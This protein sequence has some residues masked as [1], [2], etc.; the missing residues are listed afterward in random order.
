MNYWTSCCEKINGGTITGLLLPIYL[1]LVWGHSAEAQV[2]SDGTLSTTIGSVG[3]DFT[4]TGGASSGNNLYHSFSQFSVPAGGSASFSNASNIEN[5]FARVTGG[6]TSS[7]DGLLQTNGSANLFLLN[8]VGILFGPNASLDVGGSFVASTANSVIFADGVQFSTTDTTS[9]VLLTVAT[10]VGLQLGAN[11]GSIQV[12]GSLAISR[13]NTLGLAGSQ[14]DMSRASLRAPDGQIE[15]WAVQNTQ[16]ATTRQPWQLTTTPADWGTVALQQASL[17]DASGTNGGAINV[18]G[19][20]LTLQGGSNIRSNTVTGQGRGITVQTTEF[21]DLLG[22]SLPGQFFPGIGTSVGSFFGPP[23][24]GRAGDVT[25]ETGRLSLSNG[26]SLQSSSSSNNS[27]SG[28]LTVRASDVEVVGFNPFFKSPTSITTTL[29]SG[30]NN[31]SGTVTIEAD[32]LSVIDGGLISTSLV[33]LNPAASLMGRSGNISIRATESFEISGSTPNDVLSGVSTGIQPFAEGQAGDITVD[34]GRLQISNGGSIRSSLAGTGQAGN[35]SIQA[36]EVSVSEPEIDRTSNLPGGITVAVG[37]DA[38][39]PGGTINL[40]ADRLR[41]FDGGQITSSSSGQGAAGNINLQVRDI[42]IQGISQAPV[43]GQYRSSAIAASSASTFDA[44]SVNLTADSI[45]VSDRGQVTVSN[46]GTGNAGNLSA[47]ARNILLDN[48]ASLRAEVNGGDQGNINLQIDEVLLLR[49]GSN[50]TTNAQ[51]A[52][53]GGNININAGFIVAVPD[54]NSDIVANA[55]LGSGGNINITT[56]G[57][58]GLEFRD[59]LTLQSDITASSEFGVNGTVNIDNPDIDPNSGII[60]LPSQLVDAS[61]QIASGCADVGENTFVATG[62]GGV[63][64]APGDEMA[65]PVWNDIRDFS[66]FVSQGEA[67]AEPVLTSQN[68]D[69]ITEIT[70]WLVNAEGQVELISTT[71]GEGGAMNE[72]IAYATCSSLG[73]PSNS[74][75]ASQ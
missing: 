29:F 32:R 10:P 19:R 51:G 41:V 53:T 54:E 42:D 44:G 57:I 30:T 52:S 20:G 64:P 59:Q 39:G 31:E 58:F 61:D 15:L 60:E 1:S 75:S 50:I 9:G 70:G 7:I 55:V 13:G 36:T 28:D 37:S 6:S 47:T 27:R 16:I 4:I 46:S 71:L 26:A 17:V 69:T 21:V 65:S 22:A 72:A 48:G 74:Y 24:I 11:A 34:A 25:V 5:I 45:R 8:P 63:P 67:T 73:Q 12:Q 40:T 2:I 49:H 18:R 68:N 66:T 33:N 62:R 38:V 3:S 56:Q 23:Q 43:G 14:I 35:I